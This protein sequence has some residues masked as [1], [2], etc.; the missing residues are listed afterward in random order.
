M[1][2]R[3]LAGK[4]VSLRLLK[5]VP[6][7]VLVAKSLHRFELVTELQSGNP[8]SA[9]VQRYS[10]ITITLGSPDPQFGV[11]VNRTSKQIEMDK[12][13]T[14]DGGRTWFVKEVKI[15]AM[16]FGQAW[17]PKEPGTVR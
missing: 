11:N 17:Q 13:V 1:G 4:Y 12:P 10:N 15:P 6:Y 16:I 2:Q 7:T 5:R 14:A 3:Q 8:G 9:E